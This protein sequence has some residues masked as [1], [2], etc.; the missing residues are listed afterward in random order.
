MSD[1]SPPHRRSVDAEDIFLYVIAFFFPPLPVFIRSGFWTNQFLLNV[2]LTMMFG[3][4]GTLHSIYI[5]YITS[6]ITGNQG[7]RVAHSD[8]ERLAESDQPALQVSSQDTY[9]TPGPS[10]DLSSDQPP[11]YSTGDIHEATD[12][13]VQH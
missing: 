4:P 9:N 5:V 11:P 8:Y 7:R 2:L 12:N 6:P 1:S 13:K 3:L 10:G